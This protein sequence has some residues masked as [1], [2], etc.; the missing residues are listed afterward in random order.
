MTRRACLALFAALSGL[1]RRSP[2]PAPP[3]LGIDWGAGESQTVWL[4]RHGSRLR[5]LAADYDYLSDPDA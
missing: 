1:V 4:L 3:H 2:T 5:S